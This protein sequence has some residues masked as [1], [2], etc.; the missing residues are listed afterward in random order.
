M[1]DNLQRA[2]EMIDDGKAPTLDMVFNL[3][4]EQQNVVATQVSENLDDREQ[5]LYDDNRDM[6]DTVREANPN[7]TEPTLDYN[8]L[9]FQRIVVPDGSL[10]AEHHF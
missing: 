5:S 4:D 3:N 2:L 8:E 9:Q 1:D 10:I 6:A 7:S